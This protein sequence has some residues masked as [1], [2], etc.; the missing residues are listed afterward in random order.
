MVYFAYYV[1]QKILKK[2]RLPKTAIL[3]SFLALL[4]WLPGLYFFSTKAKTTMVTPAQSRN[5]NQ[6][7]ILFN[8][9]DSHDIWHIL[10][11]AG[12]YSTFVLLLIL[13]D[14]VIDVPRKELKVF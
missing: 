11:A 14:G 4:C 6:E 1:V 3:L 12:L 2:E 7:C 8:F 9:Y 10:S 13:D 5:M